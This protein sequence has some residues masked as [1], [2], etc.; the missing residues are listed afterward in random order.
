MTVTYSLSFILIL[1]TKKMYQGG[2]QKLLKITFSQ[3][4]QY[5]KLIHLLI[6]ASFIQVSV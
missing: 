1:E 6:S 3:L 2:F 4:V 5:S